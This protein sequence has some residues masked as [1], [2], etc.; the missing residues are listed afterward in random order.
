MIDEKETSTSVI[1]F[2]TALSSKE[3]I[4]K[5]FEMAADFFQKGD[6]KNL[7]DIDVMLTDRFIEYLRT[8]TFDELNEFKYAL[9]AFIDT[10]LGDQL[11]ES[12]EGKRYYYRW[13]HFHDL[14]ET[15]VEN[16]DPQL[17]KRFIESRKHGKELMT[18]L[19][20]YK[21]EGLRHNEL[22]QQ[23]GI[24]PPHLSKLLREFIEHELIT[25]ERQNKFSI[26]RLSIIGNAYM[27]ENESK[28]EM[29]QDTGT[30]YHLE[31]YPD[32]TQPAAVIAGRKEEYLPLSNEFSRPV[33]FFFGPGE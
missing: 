32:N 22:A 2:E 19:Y 10:Q 27:K 26:I 18:L 5:L 6:M 11:K 28:Y 1:I 13:A 25:R 20:K 30:V 14:C 15:A 9:L 4:K 21:K 31:D 33:E 24:S 8:G 29:G 7:W 17:T 12:E 23:L 16:Y 3:P